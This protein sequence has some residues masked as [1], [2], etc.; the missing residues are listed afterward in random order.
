MIVFLQLKNITFVLSLIVIILTLAHFAGQLSIHTL[1]P[2]RLLGL[3]ELFDLNGEGNVP[4]LFS[5][6]A[7]LCSSILFVAIAV[8]K[9]GVGSSYRLHWAGMAIAFLYLAVDES[10]ALHERLIYPVRSTLQTSG[11]LYYAWL[12]PYGVLLILVCL[13]YVKFLLHLPEKTRRSLIAAAIVYLSG[14]VGFELL[15]G[16]HDELYGHENL[17]FVFLSTC[18]EFLEMSGVVMLIHTL[19]SYIS[20]EV[21]EIRLK[22]ST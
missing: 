8:A 3:G 12:V 4:T 18:E 19:L 17:T 14:A 5:T 22:I 20:T 15:G 6:F 21:G 2:Q 16:R 13:A 7:L 9:K 11:V 10:V 1:G